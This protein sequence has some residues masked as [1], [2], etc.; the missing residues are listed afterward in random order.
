MQGWLDGIASTP[1]SNR[2]RSGGWNRWFG[3]L[4]IR[5]GPLVI[6]ALEENMLIAGLVANLK[7]C[8]LI[9]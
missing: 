4:S 5:I 1:M 2:R 9:A 8:P 7:Y 6:L 3:T